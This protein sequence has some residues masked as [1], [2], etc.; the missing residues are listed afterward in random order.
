MTL[1][2][3]GYL[4]ALTGAFGLWL[5]GYESAAVTLTLTIC[6]T[7]LGIES[8]THANAGNGS[9]DALGRGHDGRDEVV[10]ESIAS[11]AQLLQEL[12][13]SS[14]QVLAELKVQPAIDI[15]AGKNAGPVHTAS[16]RRSWARSEG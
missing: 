8:V 14:S 4:V 2:V 13:S 11:V 16:I 3:L 10:L 9:R 6:S 1:R 12:A 7:A 15:H 5:L